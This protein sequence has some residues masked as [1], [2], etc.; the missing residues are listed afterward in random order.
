MLVVGG[1]KGSD[2]NW[3]KARAAAE[4]PAQR[5]NPPDDNVTDFTKP[6]DFS[7]GRVAID[8]KR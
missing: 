6:R 3:L 4:R 7:S 1:T 5:Q 2:R 8:F